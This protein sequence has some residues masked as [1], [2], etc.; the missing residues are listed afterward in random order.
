MSIS[1]HIPGVV[2]GIKLLDISRLLDGCTGVGD[3][4]GLTDEGLLDTT[5]STGT[6]DD[7]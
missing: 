1:L 7:S 6:E 3:G 2:I 4:R 5:G